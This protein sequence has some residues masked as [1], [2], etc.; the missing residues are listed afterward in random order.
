MTKTI[1]SVIGDFNVQKLQQKN[2]ELHAT[3]TPRLFIETIKSA[4]EQYKSGD[5]QVKGMKKKYQVGDYVAIGVFVAKAITYNL[6]LPAKGDEVETEVLFIQTNSG[7][8]YYDYF[9]NVIGKSPSELNLKPDSL[10]EFQS[11]VLT[12]EADEPSGYYKVLYSIGDSPELS[13]IIPAI[14]DDDAASK[15]LNGQVRMVLTISK[16]SAVE[17]GLNFYNN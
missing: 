16:A 6:S 3:G 15:I 2:E 17:R 5:F 7:G 4:I 12:D 1:K 10:G 13:L 11:F 8:Y 9:N 14:N